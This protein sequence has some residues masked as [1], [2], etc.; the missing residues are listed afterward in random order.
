VN[1]SR[2]WLIVS[3]LVFLALTLFA[4]STLAQSSYSA[5]PLG[6]AATFAV[7]AAQT[8]GNTGSSVI[9]G[10]VGVSPGKEITGTQP[11][12]VSGALHLGDSASALAQS[13]LATG[14]A[15]AQRQTCGLDLGATNLG[16]LTLIPGVKCFSTNTQLSG[17]LTLD[18]QGDQNAVFILKIQGTLTTASKAVVKLQGGGQACNVY[19]I[20]GGS[21]T[22]GQSSALVG[23][24]LTLGSVTMNTGAK[25]EGRVLS[26]NGSVTLDTA[27]ISRPA[28]RTTSTATVAASPSSAFVTATASPGAS[29]ATTASPKAYPISQTPQ[30]IVPNAPPN[31]GGGPYLGGLYLG[32]FILV[33]LLGLV[34]LASLA[35]KRPSPKP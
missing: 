22:I 11:Q 21:A 1:L 8:L 7:L 20:V 14:Y 24:I 33:M 19:W 5:P 4:R 32:V 3:T 12:I 30:P 28:C 35:N 17:T 13:D 31:T 15:E 9:T 16:G 27:T 25:V 29:P 18:G 10:D 6:S 34:S 26:Q 23:N 2:R